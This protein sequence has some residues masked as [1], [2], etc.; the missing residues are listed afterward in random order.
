[1]CSVWPSS[2]RP[3]SELV[4]SVAS[5]ELNILRRMWL[6]C[7]MEVD[8]AVLGDVARQC[9]LHLRARFLTPKYPLD[10]LSFLV[11]AASFITFRCCQR[12]S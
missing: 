1:M 11:L 7:V 8:I 4:A 10:L 12:C 2:P 6:R 5:I 9:H 3:N